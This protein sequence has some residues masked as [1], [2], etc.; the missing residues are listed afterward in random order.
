MSTIA[1]TP[2][3][4]GVVATAAAANATYTAIATGT[5]ALDSTNTQTE[6]V[7]QEHVDTTAKDAVWNTDMATFC[8]ASLT[9]TL[10]SESFVAI[11]LGGTTPVRINFTPNLVWDRAYELLRIHADINVD[12]VGA[13]S[14]PAI[15]GSNQDCFYLQLWYLDN[16]NTWISVSTCQ[17][18]Y[19]ITNYTEFDVTAVNAGPHG[20]YDASTDLQNYAL[21]HPRHR[22]RCSVTGFLLPVANGIKAIELRAKLDTVATIAS[23]TFKEA[24]MACVMVRN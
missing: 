15:L 5:A 8:N 3:L 21:T 23:V 16:T 19:S 10:T 6:W 24:T 9:Y 1:T 11:N 20:P 12:A 4:N 2:V 14:L 22:L 7:S 18:G 13:V 17:W